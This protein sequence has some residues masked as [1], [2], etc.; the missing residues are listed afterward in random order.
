MGGRRLIE[1]RPWSFL[2]PSLDAAG[3]DVPA[4]TASAQPIP[5]AAVGAT[6][7]R[8]RLGHI[9]AARAASKAI[10]I[11]VGGVLI[12]D[13]LPAAAAA[14]STR[15]G[16]TQQAFLSAL[17]GGSDDQVLTGRVSEPAWWGRRRQPAGAGPPLLAELREDLA[18]REA[19]DQALV[20]LLRRLPGRAKTAIVSNAWPGARARMSQTGMLGIADEMVL[21][22][23]TGYAKP[24]PRI[25]QVAL[26]RLQASPGDALF[27][28]DTPGHVTAAESLGM[29]G[30]VHTNTADTITR[31]EDFLST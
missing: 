17:F 30:H 8:R 12:P 11:D 7:P 4:Q 1:R 28:D 21:S 5:P 29:T 31:I 14:W 20:A 19:W 27:V 2:N 10:L 15:L 22:C 16:I 6:D 26:Q 25:Y 13:Y 24:D 23:E 9:A 18:S 3:A